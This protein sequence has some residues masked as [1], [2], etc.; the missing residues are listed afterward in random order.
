MEIPWCPGGGVFLSRPL[1]LG[2]LCPAGPALSHVAPPTS[3]TSS[4]FSSGLIFPIS[5]TQTGVQGLAS[6]LEEGR[7]INKE[8]ALWAACRVHCPD[9]A[10]LG[11]AGLGGWLLVSWP[12]HSWSSGWSGDSGRGQVQLPMTLSK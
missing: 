10:L 2:S 11:W 5:Q 8:A 7:A 6:S 1:G 4:P 12:D 9:G 3:S